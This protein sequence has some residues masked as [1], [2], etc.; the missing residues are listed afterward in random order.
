MTQAEAEAGTITG[1]RVISPSVFKSAVLAIAK[2]ITD[3]WLPQSVV[4]IVEVGTSGGWAYRK[5]S[6][7]TAECWGTFSG[8]VS[9]W[10]QWGGTYYSTLIAKKT[11]PS[12]LFV[13]TP[14][15]N[16]TLQQSSGDA[17]LALN[18]AVTKDETTAFYLMRGT[19]GGNTS[20]A[21]GIKAVGRWE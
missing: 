13:D 3:K 14:T 20:Y 1:L 17:W 2:T 4:H 9:S 11:F 10:T 21:L 6:D 15:C 7:G 19:S 18:G 8:T 16:A 12:G 5:W